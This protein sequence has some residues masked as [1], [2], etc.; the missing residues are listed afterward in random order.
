MRVEGLAETTEIAVDAVE[1]Q[2][3]TWGFLRAGSQES[4]PVN[5][6]NTST[7][8]AVMG[9]RRWEECSA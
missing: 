5:V 4:W 6:V 7:G 3:S 9:G 8:G 1:S 2:S